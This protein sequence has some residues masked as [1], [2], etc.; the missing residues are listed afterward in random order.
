MI[1]LDS[2]QSRYQYF[3]KLSDEV[4]SKSYPQCDTDLIYSLLDASLVRDQS[5]ADYPAFADQIDG[6]IQEELDPVREVNGEKNHDHEL[7]DE[8]LSVLETMYP[9]QETLGSFAQVNGD[10]V[11][12]RD[13][14]NEFIEAEEPK[15]AH[16]ALYRFE[17]W[18]QDDLDNMDK[19]DQDI[20]VYNGLRILLDRREKGEKFS[21]M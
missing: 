1:S 14:A 4:D 11:H 20:A 3:Q 12:G 2:Q 9:F 13:I 7:S 10:I 8:E 17:D 16:S 5:R 21:S 19:P 15:D 18:Y 6:I